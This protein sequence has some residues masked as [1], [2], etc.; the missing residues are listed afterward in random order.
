ML[1]TGDHI[2]IK[3]KKV[4]LKDIKNT[5]FERIT[6]SKITDFVSYQSDYVSADMYEYYYNE[7]SIENQDFISILDV[8]NLRIHH[9][10]YSANFYEFLYNLKGVKNIILDMDFLDEEYLDLEQL[11]SNVNTIIDVI[12]NCGEIHES[13]FDVPN[14]ILEVYKNIEIQL[15]YSEKVKTVT[16]EMIRANDML[17]IILK[18]IPKNIKVIVK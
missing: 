14:V 8:E 7:Y 17:P 10:Y 3:N 2:R 16:I 18:T 13:H 4:H 11:P 6:I 1:L 5:H 12:S 9:C 15:T